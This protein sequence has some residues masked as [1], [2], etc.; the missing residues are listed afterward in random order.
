M[1]TLSL[2]RYFLSSFV[3][4]LV[5]CLS[6]CKEKG[7]TDPRAINYNSVADDD[8]GSCIVCTTTTSETDNTYTTLYD[9]NWSSIHYNEAVA[10]FY[11]KQTTDQYN[12]SACG[13]NVCEIFYKIENLVNEEM[14]FTY[15]LYTSGFI[16]FNTYPYKNVDLLSHHTTEEYFIQN[17]SNSCGS[18]SASSIVIVLSNPIIYH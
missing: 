15:Y 1:K 16:S 8:D 2:A 5:C 9:T 18:L 3:F 6:S 12:N 13:A 14:E 4:L 17:A 10:R 7:C 11:F